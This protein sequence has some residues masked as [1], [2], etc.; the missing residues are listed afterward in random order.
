MK[1]RQEFVELALHQSVPFADLCRRFGVSRQT[2]YKWL[3]RYKKDGIAGL[4]D[5]S[6]RPLHSPSITPPALEQHVLGVRARNPAWGARKIA[7]FLRDQTP[8]PPPATSTITGILHR[9]DRITPRA[10]ADATS[11]QRFEREQPNELWQMDF[12]GHFATVGEG[13]CHPLT[14]L[15]DH[16]R[17]NVVLQACAFETTATVQAHLER[18][19]ATYG[20]PRQI[21]TDNGA[22]WGASRQLGQLTELA[23]W[24]IRLGIRVSYSRPY[25]PQTNG[26][27]ERFHRSLKAEVLERAIKARKHRPIFVVDLAVPRDVEPEVAELDDVFLYSV[28]D[29]GEIVKEGL[30]SRQ[31][32][33]AQ[34]EAIIDT[35]VVNFM[36]WLESRE[37]VPTIRALR[38]QAER[39]RRHEL[40]RA[41]K[42]L[43]KGE[44]PHQILESLS[45]G[46][47]NKF[48]HIPSYALNHAVAD[49]RDD[50]VELINR[51]YHLHRSE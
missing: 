51:L 45:N 28:D 37:V 30:D 49:E 2:G 16:S 21:N 40:D 18:A 22:P 42:L 15:D 33:V 39:Y 9:H 50:L 47:T 44:D 11:W 38:D 3:N 26:K 24:L 25:H 7:R 13:R 27:N 17:F 35:N 19:F 48:L 46:L 31:G 43:A 36:H 6:R 41:K 29:L 1:L 32:A 20:L 34:A 10:S 4:A 23:I 5:Q 8:V 14:V 12:K